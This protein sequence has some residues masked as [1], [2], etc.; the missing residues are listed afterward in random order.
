MTPA[1]GVFVLRDTGSLVAMQPASFATEDDF[2]QLIARFPTLLAGDQIDPASPRR[3]QL[4]SREHG[5]ADAEGAGARWSLDHLFVDQDGVPTLVEIKRA[6]DTR[7]RREVVGQM[8]DYAANGTRYWPVEAIRAKFEAGC[9]DENS[10][11]GEVLAGLLGQEVDPD[12][13]WSRVG[14]HLA[15]GRVRLLFVADH[16]P[17]ELRCV[18]E[19]LNRQMQPAEVLAIELRQ[20]QGE[21]LRTLVPIVIG[22]TQDAAQRKGAA[23]PQA[24]K[25]RWDEAS[26]LAELEARTGPDVVARVRAV[27]DWS[28]RAADRIFFGEGQMPSFGPVFA[29]DGQTLYPFS[30]WGDGGLAIQC[31][32]LVGKPVFGAEAMRRAFLERL[33]AIGFGLPETALTKRPTVK[34]EVWTGPGRVEAFLAVMDWFVAELKR[35]GD[36]HPAVPPTP[37]GP[38]EWED[39]RSLGDLGGHASATIPGLDVPAAAPGAAA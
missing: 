24:A 39:D 15:A 30:L 18:V 25:R 26:F 29:L 32:Y 5:V 23:R 11:P 2:Q 1:A 17:P 33:N 38:A 6:T 7:L 12:A 16:I 36:L 10:D 37:A 9:R 14:E 3:F 22:Q 21:G 19:F 20:Y 34:P 8:L 13:F 27:L 4:V 35:D 28:N 31:Q